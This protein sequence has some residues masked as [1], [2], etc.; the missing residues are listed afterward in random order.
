MANVIFYSTS[1]VLL[2]IAK[3]DDIYINLYKICN[4]IDDITQ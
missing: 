1:L 2:L 3:F 4:F